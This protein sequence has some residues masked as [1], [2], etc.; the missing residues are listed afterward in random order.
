MFG[1]MLLG[2][3]ATVFELVFLDFAAQ[4]V[5]V[6]TKKARGAA[7]IAVGMVHGALDEAPFEFCE[8]LIE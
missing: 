4:R 8:R 1:E 3:A 6:N 2:V 5:A 7:P